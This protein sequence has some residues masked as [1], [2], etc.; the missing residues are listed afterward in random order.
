MVVGMTR[1]FF[2]PYA[3]GLVLGSAVLSMVTACRESKQESKPEPA[4]TAT[5]RGTVE[6]ASQDASPSS[7]T[8]TTS[9]GPPVDNGHD[10]LA[11]VD[12]GHDGGR[13]RRRLAAGGGDASVEPPPAP[14]PT[15]AAVGSA[16]PDENARRKHATM[17]DDL[18]YG[19]SGAGAAT[20][21]V[22]QK[23]PMGDDD[24]WA[25]QQ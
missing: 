18:P 20:A 24:P 23:K 2:Q 15:P 6:T 21:P 16:V 11:I 14:E 7:V 19:S 12:A 13:K 10:H 1:R 8:T 4:P 5:A 22:L 25:K 3:V 17:G 9:D